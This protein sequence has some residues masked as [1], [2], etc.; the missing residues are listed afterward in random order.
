[1]NDRAEYEIARGERAQQLLTD[2]LLVESFEAVE[3]ELMQ[4]WQNS[5]V[6]D[7]VG[8]EKLYLTLMCLRTAHRHLNTVLETGVMAKATL[9]QR[10]GQTLRSVFSK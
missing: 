4:R 7:A 6:N 9:A 3:Q 10:A 1:M 5:P 8:R 2:P